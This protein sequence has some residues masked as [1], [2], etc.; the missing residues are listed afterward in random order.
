MSQ[1]PITTN[2]VKEHGLDPNADEVAF[3]RKLEKKSNAL[4]LA[5]KKKDQALKDIASELKRPAENHKLMQIA[6]PARTCLN[7]VKQS[8][9]NSK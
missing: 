5:V 1:T 7:I 2:F 8:T 9:N 6:K 4:S 3:M